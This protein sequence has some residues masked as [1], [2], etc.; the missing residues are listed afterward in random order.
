MTLKHNN[1][2]NLQIMPN[3]AIVQNKQTYLN[4]LNQLCEQ[5]MAEGNLRCALQAEKMIGDANGF[6]IKKKKTTLSLEEM[7]EDDIDV[8]IEQLQARDESRQYV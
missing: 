7:T 1:F 4:R 6:F 2:P 8:L 5:A 3:T